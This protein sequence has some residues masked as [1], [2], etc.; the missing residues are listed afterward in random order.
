[1]QCQRCGRVLN[2]EER[3]CPNCLASLSNE[4]ISQREQTVYALKE[5]VDH[6]RSN[7]W[8][9]HVKRAMISGALVP[10]LLALTL[11]PA[12]VACGVVLGSATGWLL[13]WRHWGH[14]RAGFIYA[15]AMALPTLACVGGSVYTMFFIFLLVICTGSLIGIAVDSTRTL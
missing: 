7:M 4:R 12:L 6:E 8:N 11:N 10:L 14:N 9:R 15:A 1:M 5:A 13:A 3:R 2:L